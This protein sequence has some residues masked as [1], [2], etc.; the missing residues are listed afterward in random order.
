MYYLSGL[1][2]ECRAVSVSV[3]EHVYINSLIYPAPLTPEYASSMRERF[4]GLV[5]IQ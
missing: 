3:R 4:H 5:Y 1:M 2:E